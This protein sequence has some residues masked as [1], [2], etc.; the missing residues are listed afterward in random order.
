[1]LM[2]P[3]RLFLALSAE[4]LAPALKPLLK[5]LKENLD[6]R[7]ITARW[8]PAELLHVTILFFGET[9]LEKRDT[10]IRLFDALLPAKEAFT[11]KIEGLSAFNSPD[12]ARVLWIGV[13]NSRRLRGLRSDLIEPLVAEGWPLGD[14]YE[15]HLTIGR[16]RNP[17]GLRDLIAQFRSVDLGK[18]AVKELVLFE[19]VLQ[20][21]FPQ[22]KI[23]RRWPLAEPAATAEF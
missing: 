3:P 16:L 17:Q 9:S 10:L 12:E 14:D 11:L 5:K 2:K 22:Y 19:S 13:Q 7:E 18:I 23:V 8:V 21:P 20:T 1:M 6:R 15:P 4:P